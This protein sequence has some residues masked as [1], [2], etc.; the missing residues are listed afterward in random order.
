MAGYRFWLQSSLSVVIALAAASVGQSQTPEP[1]PANPFSAVRM[2]QIN[3]PAAAQTH[4]CKIYSLSD[5]G[6]DPKLCKW[7]A[8]TIPEMIQPATWK[9]EDGKISFYAPS[10]ILV[11]SNT[12]FVHAQV[13]EFLQ[14]MRKSLPQAKAMAFPTIYPSVTQAQFA[15]PDGVRPIGPVQT[16]P[17]GYPVPQAS[18]TP[19]HLFH[20][21]IRYEGAGIVDSN[22][23][24][25][26]K[27]LK[28]EKTPSVTEAP[29]TPVLPPPPVVGT[30]ATYGYPPSPFPPTQVIPAI[31]TVTTIPA[32]PAKSNAPQM[33]PADGPP[34][35]PTLN[36]ATSSP[37]ITPPFALPEQLPAPSTV[38]GIP[39]QVRTPSR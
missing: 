25:L 20:F 9:H 2:T 18:Q 14:T 33:P 11:I 23:V 29:T 10:K 13:E 26:V 32:G 34:P 31:P 16:G 15:V 24:K 7:V 12:P 3:K 17:Y 38:P 1:L 28:E 37:P 6:D 36:P 27:V 5:L 35:P 8:E 39:F 21:I 30:G 22:V 19:K 4:T